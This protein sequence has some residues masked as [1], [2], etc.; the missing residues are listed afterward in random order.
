MHSQRTKILTPFILLFLPFLMLERIFRSN[1]ITKLL[2]LVIIVLLPIFLIITS[3]HVLTT[4]QYLAFEYGKAGFPPD[5]FG[6]AQRE[7]YNLASSTIHY[8][9]AHLPKNVL[10]NQ[11][12]NGMPVYNSREVSHMA[13]VRAVFQTVFRVWQFTLILLVLMGF[14]LWQKR[15]LR[16][17]GSAIQRGGLL[18][19]GVI[20]LIALF[21]V[22][23]WQSWFSTF[24]LLFFK[25]GSWL[26]S[27]SD[28]LIRLFP[29]Q[30]WVDATL[31]ILLMSFM[32]GLLL[33]GIGWRWQKVVDKPLS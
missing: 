16:T 8:V 30:F 24:H 3:V 7:R 21:A 11:I 2:K 28:T 31:A 13:D 29:V 12:L 15:E 22:F 17:L 23:A 14:M 6:F 25:P 19:A 26:F 10:S 18:T 1:R 33:M 27:Y 9:R 32:G 4:D 20:L 5:S